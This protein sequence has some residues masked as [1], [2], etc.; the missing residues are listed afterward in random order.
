[1]CS[2]SSKIYQTDGGSAHLQVLQGLGQE[3]VLIL[4]LSQ[5]LEQL[6][7]SGIT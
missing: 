4:G 5:P 1:M 6:Q 3:L 2:M 7:E